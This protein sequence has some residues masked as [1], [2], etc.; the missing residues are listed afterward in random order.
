ML[1]RQAEEVLFP[2][3]H[4][5]FQC[6]TEGEGEGDGLLCMS[7]P[8]S[9]LPFSSS[10]PHA[11]TLPLTYSALLSL[12]IFITPHTA[13][14]TQ[15]NTHKPTNTHTQTHTQTHTH[16]LWARP[17]LI[18][19]LCSTPAMEINTQT[20]RPA[21]YLAQTHTHTHTHPHIHTRH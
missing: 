9:A 4:P 13:T 2:Q 17:M 10:Q 18:S 8:Q 5:A 21:C 14:H 11:Q 7:L 16:T 12:S 6:H 19:E 1:F 20:L 15:T 3:G